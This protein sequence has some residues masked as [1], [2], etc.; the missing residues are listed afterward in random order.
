MADEHKLLTVEQVHALVVKAWELEEEF[1]RELRALR[2]ELGARGALGACVTY[3]VAD[4]LDKL[5]ATQDRITVI[6]EAIE[7]ERSRISGEA[8]LTMDE[9]VRAIARS[10]NLELPQN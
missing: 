7:A 9:E 8:E 1:H 6:R 5:R 3:S 10:L 4:G 2:P